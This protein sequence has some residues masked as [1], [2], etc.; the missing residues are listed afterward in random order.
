MKCEPETGDGFFGGGCVRNTFR[1][2]SRADGP[3]AVSIKT[4]VIEVFSTRLD[5]LRQ[6]RAVSAFPEAIIKVL[7]L[8]RTPI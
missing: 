8:R 3:S 6:R 7:A 1:I 4:D 2:E 5:E